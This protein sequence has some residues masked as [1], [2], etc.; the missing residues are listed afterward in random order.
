MFYDGYVKDYMSKRTIGIIVGIIVVIIIL[1]LIVSTSSQNHTSNNSVATNTPVPTPYAQSILS[2][3]PTIVTI[4]AGSVAPQ[5]VNLMLTTGEN[6][7]TGVQIILTYNPKAFSAVAIDPG[8]LFTNPIVLEKK[9]DSQA[10]T[11]SYVY[12]ITPGQKPHKGSGLVAVLTLTPVANPVDASG[13][14]LT[15]TTIQLSP[16]SEVSAVGVENS[17]LNSSAF[18]SALTINFQ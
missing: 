10:G 8:T 16:K 13:N 2:F 5:K 3:D 7:D 15:Q 17:T 1:L 14:K 12:A 9:I 6:N 11:I 4:P 18:T